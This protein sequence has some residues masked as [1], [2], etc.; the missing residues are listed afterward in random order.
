M[1]KIRID[2][3]FDYYSLFLSGKRTPVSGRR[4][5]F[6]GFDDRFLFFVHDYLGSASGYT[7]SENVSGM[8]LSQD[9][10]FPTPTEAV[11][12]TWK[13]LQGQADSPEKLLELI[14]AK[15][16]EMANAKI[17]PRAKKVRRET[18]RRKA[19]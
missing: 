6:P 19:L 8:N 18:N 12:H 11:K 5:F 4:V 2:K 13:L 17:R 10:P 14:T 9:L 16:E 15:K 3:E 1:E 7:V